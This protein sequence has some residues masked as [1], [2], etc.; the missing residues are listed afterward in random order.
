MQTISLSIKE[1]AKLLDK[2]CVKGHSKQCKQSAKHGWDAVIVD[3]VRYVMN[4]GNED[5]SEMLHG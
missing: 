3:D 1:Y 4:E 5:L 2:I